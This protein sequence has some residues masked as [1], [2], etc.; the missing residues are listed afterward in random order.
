M[1]SL[2]YALKKEWYNII[3]LFF[4]FLI[5]PF[6]WEQLPAKIPTQWNFQGEVTGYS[7]KTFGLLIIPAINITI[8]LVLLYLPKIS[9]PVLAV[10]GKKDTQ[11]LLDKSKSLAENHSNNQ[12]LII[13]YVSLTMLI[14]CSS[15]QK[16]GPYKN[17]E[18]SKRNLWMT[19]FQLLPNG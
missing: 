3:L 19:S 14:I 17:M 18:N 10:Y 15:Q 1:N 8:Y 16:Q 13:Q 5:V 12:E 7:S 9:V 2:K 11:V 6:V 4:S